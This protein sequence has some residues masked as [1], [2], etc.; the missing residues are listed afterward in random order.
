MPIFCY[1]TIKRINNQICN[2]GV[3]IIPCKMNQSCQFSGEAVDYHGR[4][5][6]CMS[7]F[8]VLVDGAPTS[9]FELMGILP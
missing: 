2:S 8:V 5:C 7:G 3:I 9:F 6:P 4:T 1:A